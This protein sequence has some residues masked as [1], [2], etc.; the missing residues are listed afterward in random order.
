[1]G[2]R[3]SRGAAAHAAGGGDAALATRRGAL[4][5]ALGGTLALARPALAQGPTDV[6]QLDRLLT[7]ERRLEAAYEAALERD[8]IEPRLG[9]MLLEH[10]A[11]H[12]RALEQT[13][14]GRSSPRATVPPVEWGAALRSRE[15]FARLAI[16]LETETVDAYRQVVATFRN[17]RLLLPL[18]SIMA[19]GAQH[20]VALRHA[21]GRDLLAPG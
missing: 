14:R 3:N 20:V 4:A 21:A 5:L 8:A 15:A 6:D 19:C 16:D 7:L 10:E 1:M 2:A 12:V 18:G 17:D 13:L 9:R 11:E